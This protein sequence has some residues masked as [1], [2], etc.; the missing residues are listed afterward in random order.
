MCNQRFY[1]LNDA[2]EPC[3]IWVPG[4]LYIGG[5]GLAKGYW[6][7]NEKTQAHFLIHPR[8]GERLYRTGDLGRYLPDGNIEFLGRED[9]QVKIQGYRIE[10][11]EIEAALVRHPMVQ[12][13]V[14]TAIGE[15]RGEK[16]LV[17][18]FVSQQ[19][20]PIA[21]KELR[22]FLEEHLPGYMVPSTFV[23]LEK[24][25]LTANGKVDRKAL[26][27]PIQDP[28]HHPEISQAETALVT[29][30]SQIVAKVLNIAQIDP[31]A[32]L[33]EYG[34]TS[35]SFLRM[36]N[37]LQGQLHVRLN[38]AL[39]YRLSTVIAIAQ[40]CEQQRQGGEILTGIAK[41]ITDEHTPERNQTVRL[42]TIVP[43]PGKRYEPYP[44]TDLQQ[45]YWIGQTD[46]AELGN[47]VAHG[48]MELEFQQLDLHRLNHAI[49]RLIERHDTLRSIVLPDGRQQIPGCHSTLSDSCDRLS[50]TG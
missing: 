24:L 32:N 15:A 3:P 5:I 31:H 44:L 21:Y 23:H 42:P 8:S 6:R 22:H 2:M 34:A 19:A 38:L 4:Q 27:M 10:L 41:S 1:V 14:V 7:D 33:L 29:Q 20:H 28:M 17:A 49:Q 13:A 36:V 47:V 18:Y 25:P 45:A 37:L 40:Y 48:Y 50:W 16:R 46:L 11:G 35:L 12:D 9:F 26:P 43:D 30:I 39:L